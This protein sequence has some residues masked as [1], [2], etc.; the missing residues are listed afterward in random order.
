VVAEISEELQA[1]LNAMMQTLLESGE[2]VHSV[3]MRLANMLTI[4]A[5]VA[6][7]ADLGLVDKG[8][9]F[10]DSWD[11]SRLDYTVLRGWIA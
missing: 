2:E 8:Q 3:K 1:A 7:T 6:P 5:R 11:C 10:P 4:E 9:K